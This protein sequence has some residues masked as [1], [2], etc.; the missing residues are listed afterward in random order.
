MGWLTIILCSRVVT[1]VSALFTQ[2][3]DK[4]EYN[5]RTNRVDPSGELF[6]WKIKTQAVEGKKNR[7]SNNKNHVLIIHNKAVKTAGMISG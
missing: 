4:S 6:V 3:L 1:V 5:W 2:D 7:E